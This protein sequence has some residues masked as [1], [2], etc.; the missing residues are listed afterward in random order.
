MTGVALLPKGA[1]AGVSVAVSVSDSADLGRL[2]LR[3]EHAN[4]AVSEIARAVLTSGGNLVYGG[5]VHPRGFTQLIMDELVRYGGARQQL[6]VCLAAPEHRKLPLSFLDDLENDLLPSCRLTFLD[7]GGEPTDPRAGRGNGPVELAGPDVTAAYSA[8]R[9]HV[10]A[11]SHAQV[12]VGGQLDGFRGAM[13]GVVEETVAAADAGHPIYVAG[14]FGGAAALVIRELGLADTSWLPDD[15][16]ALLADE[17][18]RTATERLRVVAHTCRDLFQAGLDS[19]DRE[20]LAWSHRP[21]EI[22]SLTAL[23]LAR[24]VGDAHPG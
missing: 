22:A 17:R 11:V 13:P 20:L 14:G 12:V 16:P 23:G 21:G 15:V 24:T 3:V 19:S 8:M 4:Y 9:R 18:I 7:E 5:R 10:A 1:L 6:I 2:G